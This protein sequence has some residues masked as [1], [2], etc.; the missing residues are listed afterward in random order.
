MP[1]GRAGTAKP[2][3]DFTA[4]MPHEEQ[5]RDGG[6]SLTV[7]IPVSGAPRTRPVSFYVVIDQ[8]DGGPAVVNRRLTMI[9]LQPAE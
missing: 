4:V 9:T 6:G 5:I 7:T 3:K 8:I 2:G 1:R